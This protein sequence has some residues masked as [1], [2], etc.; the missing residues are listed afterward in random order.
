MVCLIENASLMSE[1]LTKSID[2]VKAVTANQ[3]AKAV[4]QKTKKKK[5]KSTEEKAESGAC[6]VFAISDTFRIPQLANR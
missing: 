1:F 5:K 3:D 2:T 6:R 4:V